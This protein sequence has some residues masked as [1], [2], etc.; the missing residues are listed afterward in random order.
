MFAIDDQPVVL[1][2][3]DI[4]AFRDIA[5]GEDT[6]AV[7]SQ[8]DGTITW[9]AEPGAVI[10]QGDVLYRVDDQP[11]VVLYGEQPAYR[12]LGIAGP[13]L[14]VAVA[15]ATLSSAK[16]SLTAMT[17]PPSE[18]QLQASRQTSHW[19]RRASRPRRPPTTRWRTCRMWA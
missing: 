12:S 16:A 8:L 11:V 3:G 9:V 4:P 2:Y 19:R 13:N 14:D 17:A 5:I 7:S 1:L 6:V 10:Q 18:G 15:Q